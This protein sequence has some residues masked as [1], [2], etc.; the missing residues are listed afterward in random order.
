M[1]IDTLRIVLEFMCAVV[2]IKASEG[3]GFGFAWLVC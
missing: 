3:R 2:I 1:K